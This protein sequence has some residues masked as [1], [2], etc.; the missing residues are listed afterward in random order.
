MLRPTVGPE[1]EPMHQ[2][3]LADIEQTG[4]HNRDD[5]AGQQLAVIH[6]PGCWSP[7]LLLSLPCFISSSDSLFVER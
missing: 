7:I 4:R 5:A 2:R 1:D 3:H 6:A